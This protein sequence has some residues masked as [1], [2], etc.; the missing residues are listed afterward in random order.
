MK[1]LPRH[2]GFPPFSAAPQHPTAV[3]TSFSFEPVYKYYCDEY[4]IETGIYVN[5]YKQVNI[6]FIKIPGPGAAMSVENLL[7]RLD[8]R[9]IRRSSVP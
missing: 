6:T 9:R 7:S 4:R 8:V 5:S 1:T 3:S 2:G